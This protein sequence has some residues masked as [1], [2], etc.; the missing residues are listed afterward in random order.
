MKG[1]GSPQQ[2]QGHGRGYFGGRCGR[3]SPATPNHQGGNIDTIGAYLDL[4]PAKD[5]A[6]GAVTKWMGKLVL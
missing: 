2:Q 4:P 6:P 1:R 3:G 5:I